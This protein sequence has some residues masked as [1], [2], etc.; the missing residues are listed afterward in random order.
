MR[1]FEQVELKYR[2]KETDFYYLPE[3][4]TKKSA[5]NDFKTPINFIIRPNEIVKVITNVKSYMEYDELLEI[6][7]RS[8]IGIKKNIML[9]NC[10]GLIDSD[11]YSNQDNDGNIIIA[12]YN[13]GNEI[14]E[15][16]K[17]DKIAQGVFKKYL[18]AD[19]DNSN[20]ERVGGIGS[21]N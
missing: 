11:Y 6:H 13:Y 17:G 12:L 18:I 20:E 4:S 5:G 8:S 7:I 21:T 14:Q 19:N 15:F 16:K 9:A 1:G 2:S 3:R 10:T